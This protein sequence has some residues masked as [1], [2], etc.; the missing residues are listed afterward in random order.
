MYGNRVFCLLHLFICLSMRRN[1]LYVLPHN[2]ILKNIAIIIKMN[3]SVALTFIICFL[4]SSFS[5]GISCEDK[6]YVT[7]QAGTIRGSIHTKQMPCLSMIR[8]ENS[9]LCRLT[10]VQDSCPLSCGLCNEGSKFFHCF[11]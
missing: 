5:F 7:I 4:F 11:F 6:K 8:A 10:Y 2:F 3:I 1:D 9:N